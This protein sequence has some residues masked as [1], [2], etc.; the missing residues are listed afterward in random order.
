M[1]N[2]RLKKLGG[3]SN[4]TIRYF[5]EHFIGLTLSAVKRPTFSTAVR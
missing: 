3:G 1:A 2:T 5:K 4:L